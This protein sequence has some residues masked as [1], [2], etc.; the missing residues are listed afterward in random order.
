MLSASTLACTACFD[1]SF[2][3]QS[4]R[5]SARPASSTGRASNRSPGTSR[6]SICAYRAQSSRGCIQPRSPT[7]WRRRRTDRARRSSP[8]S[9]TTPSWKQT[10]SRSSET[11]TSSSSS[12]T[13][14][15]PSIAELI[16]RM[17][18]D[19]AAD[20]LAQLDDE[21]RNRVVDLLP[22]IQQRRLRTLL[23]YEPMTA[24][25]LMSPE[26][27]ALY[28]PGNAGR[29]ARPRQKGRRAERGARL[30]LRDQHPPPLPRCGLAARPDPC[31]P[32]CPSRRAGQRTS[33]ACEPRPSSMT[34]PAR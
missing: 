23:G 29:S 34:L 26:F 33:A 32:G 27:V 31:C 5:G 9:T 10:C 1:G 2:R 7:W 6:P 18:T 8:P 4:P 11:S 14:T 24:G 20:L 15:T 12:K 21:R 25:G 22:P 28:Y 19:D 3:R 13:A 16:A 17:E 30:D